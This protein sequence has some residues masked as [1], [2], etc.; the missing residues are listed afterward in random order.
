[1]TTAIVTDST[2]SLPEGVVER[3]DV[4]VVPLT[5][6]FGPD[7]TYTDKVD[8]SNAEFY[9]KLKTSSRF[10]TT[11]QPSAGAFVEAYESLSAYD[12]VLVLTLSSK[13]SGTY[14]SALSAA[15]MVER[16]VEVIDTK[17]AEMGSGLILLE[18]LRVADEGGGFEDVKGAVEEAVRRCG[19]YFAVGTL[20]Y[21]EKSG[22]IGRAQ[23]L[24]GTALD[25]RPVLRLEDGE[26]VPHKRARG[27]KRQM[28]AI[29]DDVKPLVESG[30][31]I[32]YGQVNAPDALDDLMKA[33]GNRGRFVAEIGGVV[34]SH[35]GPGAYGVA[36]L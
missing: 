12:D 21:L 13:L 4:R 18:A 16:H 17:T 32:A 30:R 19:I 14:G 20:E 9:E 26:V 10:P 6:G 7:E 31:Q 28:A 8:L 24:L 11:S 27:R 29:V 34:G 1:M 5:F 2:T 3:P 35:V 25:I 33:L 23:R 15:G 36:Y 22:R